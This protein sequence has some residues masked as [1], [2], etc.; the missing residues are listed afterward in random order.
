[1][2]V[3]LHN[4]LYSSITEGNSEIIFKVKDEFVQPKDRAMLDFVKDYY[5]QYNKLPDVPTVEG[6]FSIQLVSNT[7]TSDYWFREI[8]AKYQEWV[9]EQAII[10]SA[11]NK[12]KAIDLFQQ[13]IVDFNVDTDAKITDYSD[14]TNRLAEYTKRKGTGGITYLPTNVPE[15]DNF[16]LGY[17]RADLWT[18]GGREGAGKSWKLLHFATM[19]DYYLLDQNIQKNIL[20]VSGEMDSMELEERLD[21]LRCN[22][23]Y[24]RLSKGSLS[25][26]EERKYRNYLSGSFESNIKI[27]D[28]FD[29]LKDIEYFMTLYRPAMCF[30]DGSHL[31][32]SSYEWTDIAKVTA[33]M[34]RMTRNKKIPIFN[35]THLKAEKGKS[36]KGGDL[37]DFA[38]TKGYTR[39]SD[40]VGVMFANDIMEVENKVGIDW[41]KVRRGDRTQMVYEHNYDKNEVKIIDVKVGTQI[42]QSNAGR[43][44]S[45]ILDDD[46]DAAY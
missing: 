20:I 28:S 29:N 32:S 23:S 33:G 44:K 7:G 2:A 24:A 25:P 39:D 8:V 17:K 9:I 30:I 14:G 15:V 21:S 1:M 42:V 19:L 6:K 10:G 43:K 34:K 45:N 37:D 36:G 11:K 18:L 27:V 22:L 31:L 46:D 13:A 40:I 12:K 35:T 16:S 38:Y 26:I 5:A 4:L 41:V 3:I